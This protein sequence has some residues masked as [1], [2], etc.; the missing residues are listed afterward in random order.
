VRIQARYV[1]YLDFQL[2]EFRDTDVA[3]LVIGYGNQTAIIEPW[4]HAGD[5]FEGERR[6]IT[7]GIFSRVNW[8]KL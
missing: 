6:G 4:D 8:D 3:K 2:P 5:L 1:F 7:Q